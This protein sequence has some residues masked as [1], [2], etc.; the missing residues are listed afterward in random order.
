[1]LKMDQRS[2]R[3]L[4][5]VGAVGSSA[6][7][8]SLHHGKRGHGPW[9]EGHVGQAILRSTACSWAACRR[10]LLLLPQTAARWSAFR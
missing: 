8:N 5:M 4:K 2:L 6:S 1:M 7:A 9:V 3:G 10:L